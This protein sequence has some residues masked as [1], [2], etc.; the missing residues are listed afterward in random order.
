MSSVPGPCVDL[1]EPEAS[2]LQVHRGRRAETGTGEGV[3]Q[4]RGD[5]DRHVAA[6]RRTASGRGIA[7]DRRSALH[8]SQLAAAVGGGADRVERRIAL[9][10]LAG[11]QRRR[12]RGRTLTAGDTTRPFRAGG[13]DSSSPDAAPE[14][15]PAASTNSTAERSSSR[16]RLIC[17]PFTCARR[18]AQAVRPRPAP[19]PPGAA[20]SL[21]WCPP[22]RSTRR[23]E[24]VRGIA[25]L[26]E[27]RAARRDA[28]HP[29]AARHD[30]AVVAPAGARVDHAVLL[31]AGDDVA[32][33][34]RARDSRARRGRR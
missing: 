18:G 23:R 7:P 4:R 21:R 34:R 15:T 26:R 3:E 20:M 19:R 28:E 12:R 27:G 22:G 10:D 14:G 11:E 31:A 29:A 2:C 8:G 33:A 30:R 6:M 17:S 1:A 9:A 16:R 24:P 13:V 5:R 25:R 32:R